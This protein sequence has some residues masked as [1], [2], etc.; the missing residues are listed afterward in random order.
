MSTG[1][2]GSSGSS[3]NELRTTRAPGTSLRPAKLLKLDRSGSW[4]NGDEG[5]SDGA[6]GEAGVN[7]CGGSDV[8][9]SKDVFESELATET[10]LATGR[11]RMARPGM[12]GA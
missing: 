1:I 3:G 11:R 6:A 4:G 8:D 12:A 2:D 5:A 9:G 10:E 7:S